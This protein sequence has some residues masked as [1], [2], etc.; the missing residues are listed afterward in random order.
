MLA[1]L[2]VVAA[3]TAAFLV[4]GLAV[5]SSFVTYYVPITVVL[6]GV[7]WLLHRS[8]RFSRT[9]LWLLV[10]IAIGN[11]AGGILL[12]DGRPL[13]VLHLV[14]DMRFDKP[15]HAFATGVGAVASIDALRSWTGRA[16]LT[17][18]VAFAAVLMATGAGSL[19]EIIEYVGSVLF[20]HT[21]V[22]DYG[23][24]MLDLVANLGGAV[25]AVALV[26]LGRSSRRVAA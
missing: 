17:G 23:D 10:A 16:A 21:N 11:M 22:G 6:T 25:A 9:T 26:A 8:A 14:G 5:G 19:V 24:N 12:V 4:Y 13:Y 7:I 18:G 20:E 3:S 2:V 15:F 1:P